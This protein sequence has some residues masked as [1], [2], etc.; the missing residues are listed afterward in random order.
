MIR[1]VVV[2]E[3][4][5]YFYEISKIVRKRDVREKGAAIGRGRI[6]HKRVA[7]VYLPELYR[8]LLNSNPTTTERDDIVA[9]RDALSAVLPRSELPRLKDDLWQARDVGMD[10]VRHVKGSECA[11]K[12]A[13]AEDGVLEHDRRGAL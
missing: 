6:P 3:S 13:A 1:L 5:L 10:D 8:L 11:A 7:S 4:E 9:T 12:Q 2:E